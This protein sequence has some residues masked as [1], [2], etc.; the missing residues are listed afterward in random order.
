[1]AKIISKNALPS[2]VSNKQAKQKKVGPCD[3]T[4]SLRIA[5][6]P[7]DCSFVMP[8]SVKASTK[9]ANSLMITPLR[10]IILTIQILLTLQLKLVQAN[11]TKTYVNYLDLESHL[12]RRLLRLSTEVLQ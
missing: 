7:I 4:P 5:M 6:D 3:A 2:N 11:F 9:S 8:Y 10:N 12:F 1:M